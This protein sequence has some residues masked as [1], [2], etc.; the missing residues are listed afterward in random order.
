[1]KLLKFILSTFSI[2]CLLII[3]SCQKYVEYKPTQKQATPSAIDSSMLTGA[4]PNK[5][6]FRYGTDPNDTPLIVDVFVPPTASATSK[7]PL[8]IFTHGTGSSETN[9]HGTGNNSKAVSFAQKQGFVTAYFNFF[10]SDQTRLLDDGKHL[11]AN[12]T[13]VVNYL[14]K[15][16]GK[17]FINTDAII[18]CGASGSA[19]GAVTV[20]L[21]KG[22][23]GC[24]LEEGGRNLAVENY[25]PGKL[26][27]PFSF[28][29]VQSQSDIGFGGYMYTTADVRSGASHNYANWTENPVLRQAEWPGKQG[30]CTAWGDCSLTESIN[31]YTGKYRNQVYSFKS[32]SLV[33]PGQHHG[34]EATTKTGWNDFV[35]AIP[36]K[37]LNDRGIVW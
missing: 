11:L 29:G 34:P 26:K 21:K 31:Y 6:S 19:A 12:Y 33:V 17:Y 8:I 22:L 24:M 1:M 25:E 15:N 20:A 9:S 36:K 3:G 35:N 14:I 23:F 30:Y 4:E 28:A 10:G 18:A 7:R 5:F 2:I 27:K 37:M 16:A 13:A 32:Y